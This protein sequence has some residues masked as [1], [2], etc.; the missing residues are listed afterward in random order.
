MLVSGGRS[1]AGAPELGASQDFRYSPLSE[2]GMNFSFLPQLSVTGT[3]PHS[4]KD[5]KPYSN[6]V[7]LLGALCYCLII[8]R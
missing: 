3:A 7:W 1:W 6:T 2:V 5:A 8:K 4:L